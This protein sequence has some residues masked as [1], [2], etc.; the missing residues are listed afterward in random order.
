MDK[1]RVIALLKKYT[2]HEHIE[3]TSRG[4]TAIFAALYVAR[5][6]RQKRKSILIPD[7]GGWLSYKTYPRH[8]EL[9]ITELKTDYGLIHPAHL[10]LALKKEDINSLVYEN[11]A[12][13][14]AHQPVSEI[15]DACS[16]KCTVVLDV[17]GCIGDPMLC[18]GEAA[19]IMV[20]SF[21]KWKPVEVGYGGFVS[22]RE[23]R[24]YEIAKEIFNTTAFDDTHLDK[25]FEKLL[26]VP[27]RL[28]SLYQQCERIKPDL[29]AYKVLHRDRKGINVVVA[30][31][32]QKEKDSIIGYCDDSAYEYTIC[33][34][35]IR[36][37]RDAVS[38]EVKREHSKKPK[39]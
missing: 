5:K 19:D 9:N 35:Y 13:Y 16:G 4:N 15:Y 34:R 24:H 3:L 22:M 21:G 23:R 1:E 31:D 7:Q 27:Q 36:V 10:A 11:P 20:G 29:S 6:L 26:G 18:K 25:L 17:S 33:P 12:G 38:I 28:E 14:F 32:S 37:M 2:G 30:Y 8:L 39:E